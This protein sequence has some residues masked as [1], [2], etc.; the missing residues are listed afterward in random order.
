MKA[1]CRTSA[2]SLAVSWQQHL[3]P[4]RFCAVVKADGR[5]D[6]CI[7]TVV[8]RSCPSCHLT[9]NSLRA[10]AQKAGGVS[11]HLG[12]HKRLQ[13]RQLKS[14]MKVVNDGT[15]LLLLVQSQSRNTNCHPGSISRSAISNVQ[16]NTVHAC[17]RLGVFQGRLAKEKE[18]L[19]A[20]PSPHL[21]H[22][23]SEVLA[24]RLLVVRWQDGHG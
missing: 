14:V 19:V 11:R 16:L 3:S 15:V 1:G 2:F 13:Q 22:P 20:T 5:A 8:L 10:C 12:R 17:L 4:R 6:R 7:E 23:A 24:R 18:S 21:T 9:T